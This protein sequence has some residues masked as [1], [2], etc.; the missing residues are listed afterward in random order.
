MNQHEYKS[1]EQRIREMRVSLAEQAIAF[2]TEALEILAT[3]PVRSLMLAER[4]MA[5]QCFGAESFGPTFEAS[6]GMPSAAILC[7]LEATEQIRERAR[8]EER[9]LLRERRALRKMRRVASKRRA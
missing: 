9:A 1:A 8:A 6:N 4:A 7:A 5:L 3:N 2:Q